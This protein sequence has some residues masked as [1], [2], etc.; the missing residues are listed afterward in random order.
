MEGNGTDEG[1]GDQFVTR[2]LSLGQQSVSVSQ[3]ER[4]EAD[5]EVKQGS[6]R[7]H[8]LIPV[9]QTDGS[10]GDA[11]GALRDGRTTGHRTHGLKGRPVRRRVSGGLQVNRGRERGVRRVPRLVTDRNVVLVRV[12]A[13]I[14]AD[15]WR[16]GW[17]N[18]SFTQ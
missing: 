1:D 16:L 5:S 15:M 14:R 13:G 12:Q 11:A 3:S 17:R 6:K 18:S 8:D 4:L 9:N 10:G 7:G 2:A